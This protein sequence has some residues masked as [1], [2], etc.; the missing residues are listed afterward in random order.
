M[1]RSEMIKVIM[2]THNDEELYAAGDIPLMTEVGAAQILAA[3]EKA[4]MLAP[5]AQFEMGGTVITDH[6]WE[7]E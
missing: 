4:G 2:D 6:F 3:I 5:R 7:H 1:K